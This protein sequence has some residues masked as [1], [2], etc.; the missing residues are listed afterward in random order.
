MNALGQVFKNINQP[1]PIGSV[2][3]N[4]GHPEAPQALPN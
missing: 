4:I 3:S 2:K 1:V